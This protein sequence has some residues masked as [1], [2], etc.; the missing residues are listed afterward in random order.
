[1]N[2]IKAIAERIVASANGDRPVLLRELGGAL[3]GMDEADRIAALAWL[4]KEAKM[5]KRELQALI[6]EAQKGA[7]ELGRAAQALAAA[8]KGEH[9]GGQYFADRGLAGT[10]FLYWRKTTA[11]GVMPVLIAHFVPRVVG[12]RVR[13]LADDQIL[14]VLSCQIETVGGVIPF[15]VLPE[16]AAD[17]RRFYAACVHAAGAD[18][19]LVS[20]GGGRHLWTAAA[21]LADPGRERE[22]VFEFTGWREV[23]GKLVYLSAAG[24]IGGGPG[25]RVDLSTL[26]AGVGVPGVAQFGPRADEEDLRMGVRALG[27]VVRKCFPDR[28][29][30]PGLAAVF[31]APALRWAPVIDRPALHYV[32]AT[33]TRKTA[34]LGVLQ[35]F[36]GVTEH[37]MQWRGTAN[38]IEIALSALGDCVVTV[39]D[40][41]V[42]TSDRGGAQKI[43]QA[44]A[45]RRGRTRAT[46]TGELAR[47]RFVAGLLVSNGQDIPA[48]EASV[49]ARTLFLAVR[50]EDAQLDHLTA[51]QD[52]APFLSAI[53][54]GYIGWLLARQDAIKDDLA[55]IFE[56]ARGD[57]RALLSGRRG[58]N[59]AGRVAT[60]CALLEC[61]ARLAAEWLGTQG[62][63]PAECAE[64]VEASVAALRAA[65][66]SQAEAISEESA[67]RAW[68]MT[69]RALIDGKKAELRKVEK[70]APLPSLADCTA[71]TYGATVIGWEVGSVLYLDPSLSWNMIQQWR[72]AQGEALAMTKRGLYAELREGDWFAE[73]DPAGKTEVVKR[74]GGGVRRVLALKSEALQERTEAAEAPA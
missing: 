48:G 40:L 73:V 25:I 41:K 22:H 32:G 70:G 5:G 49:A 38:S 62:W 55:E 39:D 16:D 61:G 46:R 29:I 13:H 14:R 53:T 58:I 66:E 45:D 20:S 19:R 64:W 27:Q 17:P 35:A 34:L 37:L 67:A 28:V 23:G 31:L 57:Y 43:L 44:A 50:G 63:T 6:R 36:Y 10:P 60:N 59:D 65:A 72:R 68:L 8:E 52:I 2:S 15:D 4:P 3:A 9:D 30:L 56:T 54:A 1:M 26:A 18:A 7:G 71:T 74:I 11:E 12:E 24:A 42:S 33:G 21:E 47:A 69:L 51:A